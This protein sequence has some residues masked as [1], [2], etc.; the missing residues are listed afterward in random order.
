VPE[1]HRPGGHPYIPPDPLGVP[2]P[3]D[4]LAAEEFGI[5]A[6]EARWFPNPL[7][8]G[9]PH[10]TLAAEE[11]GIGTPDDRW[12]RDPSGYHEPHD[13]LAAEAFPMPVPDRGGAMPPDAPRNLLRML[14]IVAS[15]GAVAQVVRRRQRAAPAS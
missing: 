10:D 2:E 8:A 5:G 13:V 9:P 3:H 6:G 1:R 4:V 7:G 12:P 15:L 11:F 14:I